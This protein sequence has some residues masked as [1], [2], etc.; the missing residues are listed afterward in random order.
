MNAVSLDDALAALASVAP[1]PRAERVPLDEALGRTLAAPLVARA[2]VPNLDV[3]AMDGYAC[4][5][6]DARDAHADRPVRLRVVGSSRTGGPLPGALEAGQAFAVAT[7]AAMPE[8]AD[9]IAI[10]ERT[11][12]EGDEVLL[13]APART[14]HVR[15]IGEDLQRNVARL[16]AGR[17]LDPVA[18]GLAASLGHAEATVVRRP[19]VAVLAT[20]PELAPPG[21][22]LAP[23][24]VHDSNGP[25]VAALLRALGAEARVLPTV[26]DDEAAL[27]ASL[28]EVGAE[29]DLIV[30]TGGASI[31]RYDVVRRV[32]T[33]EGALHFDGIRVRPGRPTLLGRLRDRPWL[34]LPGTPH[35]VALLG[36]V[37]MGAWAHA[38]LGRSGD[39][40]FERRIRAICDA[41]IPGAAERTILTLARLGSDERGCRHV[42]PLPRADASR[43]LSL[44]AA[45]ALIVVPPGGSAEAGE[46]A[47]V[48]RFGATALVGG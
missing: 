36:T 47:E 45:D 4:R 37:L 42:A 41:S 10:V 7:G 19:Q 30:T 6:E 28:D 2:D 23:G 8:G 13:L 24:D 15:R 12:R 26:V 21:S 25:L 46:L 43:L 29:A 5:A 11:R 44:A 18:V 48:V 3:A 31:G 32:V 35:A 9:A 33:A 14:K 34:A 22:E 39:P 38:A 1:E 20:G 16:P 40:P 27:R 17:L